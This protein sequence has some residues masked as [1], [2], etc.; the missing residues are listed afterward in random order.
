[1]NASHAVPRV[2][3]SLDRDGLMWHSR[4]KGGSL[5]LIIHQPEILVPCFRHTDVIGTQVSTIALFEVYCGILSGWSAVQ[6]FNSR[7]SCIDQRC[8]R[9]LRKL[10]DHILL[11]DLRSLIFEA[12]LPLSWWFFFDVLNSLHGTM[13]EGA[14]TRDTCIN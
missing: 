6:Q 10:S 2:L 8:A 4:R 12:S 9:R 3:G 1:M 11:C 7:R 5:A 14:C 13:S